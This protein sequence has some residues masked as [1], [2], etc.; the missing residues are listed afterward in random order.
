M[1]AHLHI[2]LAAITVATVLG[3]GPDITPGRG[4]PASTVGTLSLSASLV[5][6]SQIGGCPLPAGADECAARTT[7]GAFP[8]L[9]QVTARYEHPMDQGPPTCA[10]G[11][12]KALAYPMR[13]TV[14]SKGE[15]HLDVAEGPCVDLEPTRTQTQTFRVTGGT[16]LYV[17][18]SGSGTLE[19]LLGEPTAT[20]R[21]GRETWK[22]TL[23]V[24]GLEFD[25][26]APTL[27]GAVNRSVRAPNGARTARVRFTLAARDDVDGA[28]PVS[29]SP[30]SGSR[31]R[32]G[33]TRVTCS[34]A[35]TSGNSARVS[36]IVT[37]RVRR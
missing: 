25:V 3:L 22:G 2:S 5:L 35:D 23:D 26:T 8:G 24:P 14:A 16:G 20:G 31:F 6:T 37:V 7:Q 30:R 4:A 29:C 33:R 9:G 27:T 19:R 28:V 15:I 13:L 18:A 12:G 34:A 36:F 17:G 11:L 1:R 21:T 10:D 32:L